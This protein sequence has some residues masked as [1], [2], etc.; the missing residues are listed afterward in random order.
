MSLEILQDPRVRATEHRD[1][2]GMGAAQT[3]LELL[4]G[5]PFLLGT[6]GCAARG[7]WLASLASSAS[8]PVAVGRAGATT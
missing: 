5:L 7:L 3:A 1:L 4:M 8:R 6:W 2:H